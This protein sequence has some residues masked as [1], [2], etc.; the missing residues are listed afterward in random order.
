MEAPQ[1][2]V[3][4][5]ARRMARAEL[6]GRHSHI[7]ASGVQVHVWVRAGKYLARGRLRGRQFGETLGATSQEA[8]RRLMALL[9]ELG[10]GAYLPPSEARQSPLA[11]GP[12]PRLTLRELAARFLTDVRAARG[13]NT[14]ANYRARLAP[15]LEFAELKAQAS[16][17]R[18]AEDIDADFARQLRSY[19]H[20]HLTTRNGRPG[21]EP[22]LLSARQILNILECARTLLAWGSRPERRLLPAGWTHPFTKDVVGDRRRKDPLRE[23]RLPLE[24]RIELVELMDGWQL[25]H[26][27]LQLVLPLRPGEAAGLLIS[28]VDFNKRLLRF[29]TRLGG[30]DFTKGRQGF[31][32]PFPEELCPILRACIDRRPEGVLLR[33]R[34]A[35]EHPSQKMAGVMT[36]DD[37]ERLYG[38]EL[39][40]SVRGKVESE[41]DRKA[42]FRRLL[43]KLG[44][45]SVD[46]L[47]SEFKK[48]FC[49]AALTGLRPY[50]LRGSVTTTMHR[51][52]VRELELRYMTGHTTGDILNEYVQLDPSGAIRPYFELIQPLLSIIA[53]RCR[54]LGLAA[55]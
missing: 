46:T 8:E 31:V 37:I 51:A 54:V 47:H 5:G 42:T 21:A 17:W 28:D 45:V 18:L 15:V 33:S 16:K 11:Q 13:E 36:F 40:R 1:Q 44:G 41:Q 12:A 9:T 49:A 6:Y 53:E 55:R 38:N 25:C 26:L 3:P 30:A 4:D 29:G 35:F 23:D 32:V 39:A 52:G 10:R 22:R 43:V 48:V 34:R 2:S 20:R 19:L 27:A 7:A 50:D 14:A 24:R